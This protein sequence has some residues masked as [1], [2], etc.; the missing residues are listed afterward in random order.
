MIKRKVDQFI[1]FKNLLRRGLLKED[2]ARSIPHD[3][4]YFPTKIFNTIHQIEDTY[5]NLFIELGNLDE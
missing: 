4:F 2:Q 3:M 5:I 1:Y